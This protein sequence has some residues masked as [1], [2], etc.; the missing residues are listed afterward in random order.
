MV[1]QHTKRGVDS[2]GTDK[3]CEVAD[4]PMVFQQTNRR[5]GEFRLFLHGPAIGSDKR[6]RRKAT[7]RLRLVPS[8]LTTKSLRD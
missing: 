8:E 1:F 5:L 6:L 7:T 3:I 4:L 2:G